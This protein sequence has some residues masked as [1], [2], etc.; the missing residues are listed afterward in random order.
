LSS[1]GEIT[2]YVGNDYSDYSDVDLNTTAIDESISDTFDELIT[3]ADDS[4][5]DTR[6]L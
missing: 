1:L 6:I 5:S 2:D 3:G 4:A